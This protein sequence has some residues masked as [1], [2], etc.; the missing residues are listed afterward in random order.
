MNGG[1]ADLEMPPHVGFGRG[2]AVELRVGVNESEELPLAGGSLRRSRVSRCPGFLGPDPLC[3]EIC[4]RS[5]MEEEHPLQQSIPI[6]HRPSPARHMIPLI[7]PL[8]RPFDPG[9]ALPLEQSV[10]DSAFDAAALLAY[11]S[12]APTFSECT[13][14]V[15]PSV[16]RDCW[17]A[18]IRIAAPSTQIPTRKTARAAFEPL[19]RADFFGRVSFFMRIDVLLDGEIVFSCLGDSVSNPSCVSV[20]RRVPE[21]RFSMAGCNQ[22]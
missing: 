19:E 5:L 20:A 1:W 14:P 6:Q 9:L 3:H 13:S 2:L 12:T 4:F 21:W 8:P 17:R 18:A 7:I 16:G 15:A 22:P 10:I 11:A